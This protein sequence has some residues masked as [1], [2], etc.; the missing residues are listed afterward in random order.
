[1]PVKYRAQWQAQGPHEMVPTQN[2]NATADRDAYDIRDA[3][4][5]KVRLLGDTR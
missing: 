2:S 4:I 1:M 5:L 3:Y